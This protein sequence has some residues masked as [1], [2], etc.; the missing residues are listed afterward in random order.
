[1]RQ[2]PEFFLYGE[3]P[4]EVDKHFLHLESLDERNR[5]AN[6]NIQAHSHADLAHLFHMAA[7]RGTMTAEG[8]AIAFEGPCL[9]IVPAGAAH[10]FAC[11][12]GTRGQVLTIARSY[13]DEIIAR[14]PALAPLF[15]E[16]RALPIDDTRL[17]DSVRRLQTELMWTAP[18]HG[19]VVEALLVM[20]LVDALRLTRTTRTEP[21][22]SPGPQTALLARFRALVEAHF[23]QDMDLAAYAAALNVT[24]KR[25]RAA[26]ARIAGCAPMEAVH[27]R[28]FL[29]AQRLM[30]YSNLTVAEA[31]YHLGFSDPAYFSRFFTR[32]CG[33]SP[34]A[35]RTQALQAA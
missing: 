6:W 24:V 25:L 16:A 3:A 19:A 9:L 15:D 10:E 29:E 28:R 11:E 21:R 12:P 31:A 30:L 7:G 33:R 13:L 23:R 14:E 18:G 32:R 35:F 5:P 4:R 22:F 20:L 17:E 2:V 27:D 26:C 1:V 8:N 34:T